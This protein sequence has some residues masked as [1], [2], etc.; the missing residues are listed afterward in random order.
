MPTSNGL[1]TSRDIR[2]GS[3]KTLHI[4]DEAVTT[5]KIPDLA[6]TFPDKID[7]PIWVS[8]FFEIL[9]SNITLVATVEQ[10]FETTIDVPAWV[11][12]VTIFASGT[13]GVVND[14]G[15]RVTMTAWILIDGDRVAA[16]NAT[17]EDT[18]WQLVTQS[19]GADLVGVAGSSVSVGLEVVTQSNDSTSNRGRISGIVIG[20]R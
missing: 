12:S 1:V 3:V 8:G 15:G 19:Y 11:D 5:P 4:L 18:E 6:V 14:S 20:R 17:A 7:D 2:Q 13:F 9:F 10:Q 16:A